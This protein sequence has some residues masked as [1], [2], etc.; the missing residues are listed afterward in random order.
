MRTLDPELAIVLRAIYSEACVTT[1]LLL[2]SA[3]PDA[4]HLFEIRQQRIASRQ[5]TWALIHSILTPGPF[6][7]FRYVP[8]KRQR[9]TTRS[10]RKK[11]RTA[12]AG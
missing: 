10:P 3:P 6:T 9:R 7:P 12:K 5:S 8:P 1:D 4:A 11:A 2:R